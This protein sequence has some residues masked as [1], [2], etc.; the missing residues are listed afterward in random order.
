[1]TDS[2]DNTPTPGEPRRASRLFQNIPH[3]APAEF[4]LAQK[5]TYARLLAGHFDRVT[6]I[7]RDHLP[8]GT[9]FRRGVPG[10]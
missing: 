5:S 3:A 10:E 7:E 8:N 2:I 1:M 9:Q 4:H 6:L